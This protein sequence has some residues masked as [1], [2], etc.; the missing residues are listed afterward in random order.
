MIKSY[1]HTIMGALMRPLSGIDELYSLA[2][3][4]DADARESLYARLLVSFR[5]VIRHRMWGDEDAEDVAQDALLAVAG[6]FDELTIESSFAA[7]AYRVLNNKIAD[8]FKLKKIR[9]GKIEQLRQQRTEAV[10]TDSNPVLKMKIKDCFEKI[11]RKHRQHARILS[12][13]FQGYTT[14]EICQR[15]GITRNNCWVTLSRA[16][17]MLEKCLNQEGEEP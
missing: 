12:L 15:L 2:H 3:G 5:V 13:R 17:A 4:G 14:D 11:H 6:Q 7:W 9:T 1:D 10:V 8:H 16:R